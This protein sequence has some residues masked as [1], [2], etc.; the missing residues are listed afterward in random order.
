[1]DCQKC[2]SSSN[3]D[4]IEFCSIPFCASA[5]ATCPCVKLRSSESTK[6]AETLPVPGKGSRGVAARRFAP[7]NS[8]LSA[9]ELQ[10]TQAIPGSQRPLFALG[11]FT[12]YLWRE[13]DSCL[14]PNKPRYF[15]KMKQ[16]QS[17]NS[18]IIDR[19]SRSLI[20]LQH[21][22]IARLNSLLSRKNSLLGCFGNWRRKHL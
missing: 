18:Q 16:K 5:H 3:R 15:I 21:S 6:G 9:A 2:E 20:P 13:W 4:A 14:A 17:Q 22:L 19:E 11:A 8:R 10:P 12:Q 1:M 7:E